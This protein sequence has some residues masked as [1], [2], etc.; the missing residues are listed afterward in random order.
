[1]ST[2]IAINTTIALTV[3]GACATLLHAA[4]F[5]KH[6]GYYKAMLYTGTVFGILTNVIVLDYLNHGLAGGSFAWEFIVGVTINRVAIWLPKIAILYRTYTIASDKTQKT[7]ILWLIGI[8]IALFVNVTISSDYDCYSFIETGYNG[9]SYP[10]DSACA[11]QIAVLITDLI[12]QCIAEVSIT[13]VQLQA[14]A[15]LMDKVLKREMKILVISNFIGLLF[16]FF[17]CIAWMLPMS[18][19]AWASTSLEIFGIEVSIYIGELYIRFVSKAIQESRTSRQQNSS[20]NNSKSVL[21]HGTTA[22]QTV[23]ASRT[24]HGATT[25]LV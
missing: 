17:R 18:N 16:S 9:V 22:S 25:T 14:F 11:S 3:I 5:Y 24:V 21:A 20:E 6:I 4:T 1:M 8:S 12:A 10:S 7:V 2:T 19:F 23:E 13:I 15:P